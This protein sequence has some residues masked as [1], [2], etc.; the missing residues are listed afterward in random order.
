MRYLALLLLALLLPAGA[1]A[2]APVVPSTQTTIAVAGTVATSTRII[3]GV[4]NQ[5]IYL[6][7]IAL[8]PVATSVVTF[9]TGTGTN[10]GTSTASL[11]GAM[12]FSDGQTLTYGVGN[13][14]VLAL[15]VGFDLCITIATAVAPGTISYAQF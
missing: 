8:V 10:C 12:T 11:T 3:T 9:T 1:Q 7:G 4:A 15:P 13:G 14:A 2:Q 5:R 6:T